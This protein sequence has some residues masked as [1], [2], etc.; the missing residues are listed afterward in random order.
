MT[1]Q[2]AGVQR[3]PNL[4]ATQIKRIHV[5]RSRLQM[6]DDAYRDLLAALFAGKRSSTEL[7]A[8][9]RAR[10]VNH[11]QRLA[12]ALPGAKAARSPRSRG[13][14][15][16]SVMSVTPLTARQRKMFSLWQ[17][18]ADAGLVNDRTMK[19]L[20]AW[21]CGRRWFGQLVANKSWL[22]GRREDQVIESL[23]RWL[24]RGED[25]VEG[26]NDT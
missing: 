20:D 10:L 11:L 7:D 13:S 19:A 22:D 16:S 21:I 5:L 2:P 23:K 6:S 9:D 18:L 26:S 4:R 17:E 3:A 8:G 24:K 15:A 14:S 12:D 1:S 25:Y